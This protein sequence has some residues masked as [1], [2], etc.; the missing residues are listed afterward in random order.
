V[1]CTNNITDMSKNTKSIRNLSLKCYYCEK[2][3]D[4][5][6]EYWI[7]NSGIHP[8]EPKQPNLGMIQMMPDKWDYDIAPKG[9][10]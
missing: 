1:F 7:H 5:E 2:E 6:G 8:E 9:N 3:F 4:N 10:P